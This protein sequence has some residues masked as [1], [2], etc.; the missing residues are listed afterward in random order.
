M[1]LPM[2]IIATVIVSDAGGI[3]V[4]RVNTGRLVQC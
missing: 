1:R 4:N 2:G 3:R